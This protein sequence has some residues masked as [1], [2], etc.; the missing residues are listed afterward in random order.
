MRPNQV[1]YTAKLASEMV[2][3]TFRLVDQGNIESTCADKGR[4]VTRSR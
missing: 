1:P 2:F 3:V 4:T